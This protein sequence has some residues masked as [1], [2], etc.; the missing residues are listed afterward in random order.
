MHHISKYRHSLMLVLAILCAVNS[1][2]AQ[3]ESTLTLD[4]VSVTE[5]SHVIIGWTLETDVQDGYIVIHRKLNDDSYAPINQV[6]LNQI[7][8]IDNGA[9][10]QDKAFSY[11]VVA[12]DL[13]DD[14][15]AISE[16]AHQTIFLREPDYDIC[17]RT[18]SVSWDNYMVTTSAGTPQPLPIPFENT[19]VQISYNDQ[20]FLAAFVSEI[21]E[22]QYFFI[23]EE[24]GKYC[25]RL[26]SY[27]SQS[28]LTSTSNT[29]CVDAKFAPTP[30]FGGFR[31]LTYEIDQQ[32]VLL[33]FLIE[34]P[35]EGAGYAI[36]RLN[37]DENIFETLDTLF[38]SESLVQFYD[39]SHMAD[40]RSET[41]RILFLDSCKVL[42][43][44]TPEISTIHAKVNT[45]SES[46][47]LIEW[48]LYEG[49]DHGVF[50]YIIT[51]RLQ[52]M[53]GFEIIGRVD[54]LTSSYIDI[55][56]GLNEIEQSGEISYIIW[57]IE[58]PTDYIPEPVYVLSN[59]ATLERETEVFVPNA[60]KPSS[61]IPVNRIFKPVFSYFTPESYSMSIFNR[62]GEEIF[63][64][65]DYQ[66]GWD[67]S[68]KSGQAP[69]GVYSYIIRY[70][71]HTG[72]AS[73]KMGTVLLVR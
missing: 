65:S 48:N 39:E 49:W 35:V 30:V 7:S 33:E 41:Y 10:P 52:G 64:T 54:P 47:N 62:W 69:A 22:D 56:S 70:T 57:A 5:N 23:P 63:S 20:E 60:F 2:F 32:R 14:R 45:I 29:M 66:S 67:G 6:G 19:E 28:D 18:I 71:D 38:T 12:W 1:L 61:N 25:F 73:E 40:L 27:T 13:N 50:E 55:L 4:S 3:D 68:Y 8:Y 11:Y 9:N 72:A 43:F 21:T 46:E 16:E 58:N 31:R 17:N 53:T 26:R 51:R 24:E 15:I 37:P 34:D 36:Q 44:E 42:S 59:I